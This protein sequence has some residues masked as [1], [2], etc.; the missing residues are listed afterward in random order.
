MTSKISEPK[1]TCLK[2]YEKESLLKNFFVFF[3]L[4]ELLLVLLFLELYHAQ[5]V[6]YKKNIFKTMQVCS[7]TFDCTPYTFDFAPKKDAI[8]NQLY[9]DDSLYSYFQIPKSKKFYLKI[10]Y[11]EKDFIADMKALTK[12]LWI[13]FI[14]ASFI[15]SML[16]LFFT[17]YSLKPIRKA[18]QLNDE[19]IKDILHDFN[20]PI[21]AMRLNMHML[22]EESGKNI[23]V[24]KLSHSLETIMM[25]QN[26]L[27]SFLHH[28]PSQVVTIDVATLAHARLRIMQN[29]YPNITF[30]YQKNADLTINSHKELLTRILDNLL[31]NAAKYN[32]PDGSVYLMVE[33]NR[34]IMQDTGHGIK[35]IK[36]VF[37][38][39]Y[40]EQA[41]GVGLGL[42]IVDKLTK[43]LGIMIEIQ[44]NQTSGTKITL[45][46]SKTKEVLS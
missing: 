12:I 26:N 9:E 10:H 4:L 29:L 20:T 16:A 31:S 6:E 21:T 15:L 37:G 30:S 22:E 1:D 11:P 17:F 43:E 38:R 34:L 44:S 3:S 35:D 18:L 46:F 5:K 40:T 36:K 28:S 45:D 7:Y 32:K 27:K 42:H 39:Y 41:R 14:I 8:L 25:L 33:K 2:S 13:K 19:F 24:Q 23:F